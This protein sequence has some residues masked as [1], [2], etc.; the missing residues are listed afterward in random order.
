M[1]IAGNVRVRSVE[2]S[3]GITANLVDVVADSDMTPMLLEQITQVSF[4]TLLAKAPKVNQVMGV[5][6]ELEAGFKAEELRR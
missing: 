5:T 1:L 4:R 3:Q 2:R 6:I